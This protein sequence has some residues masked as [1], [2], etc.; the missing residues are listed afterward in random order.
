M[1]AHEEEREAPLI[2]EMLDDEVK[3]YIRAVRE[4]GG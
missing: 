1:S 4:C 3:C 2:G